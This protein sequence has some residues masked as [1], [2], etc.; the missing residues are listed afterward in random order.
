MTKYVVKFDQVGVPGPLQQTAPAAAPLVVD[1]PTYHSKDAVI[2][3]EDAEVVK[4]LVK[5]GAIEEATDE[6]ISAAEP[7]EEQPKLTEKQALVKEAEDL[8]LD[9]SGTTADLKARI[10]KHQAGE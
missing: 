2:D 7:E 1:S 10:E 9:S 5:L 6:E 3:I 4:R 8:G